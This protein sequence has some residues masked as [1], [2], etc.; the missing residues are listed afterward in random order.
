M[1]RADLWAVAFV[2]TIATVGLSLQPAYAQAPDATQMPGPQPQEHPVMPPMNVAT[3]QALPFEAINRNEPDKLSLPRLMAAAVVAQF[4]PEPHNIADVG[5]FQGEF[6]EAFMVRFPEAHA[7]WTDAVSRPEPFARKRLARFGDRV[8]Y[9]V[10]CL[11]GDISDGCIPKNTDVII[12]S[13]VTMHQPLA[14]IARFYEQARAQLPSGGW[15]IILDHVG[16]PADSQWEGPLKR[17]QSEFHAKTEGPPPFVKT[18]VPT[19]A[20]EM[21][22]FKVA[23]FDDVQVVWR[24]FTDA[25]FMA[26]KQ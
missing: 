25:L 1:T 11:D 3:F 20:E 19:F 5:A 17:A 22:A 24:S 23:G 13:W 21:A 7:L 26:R 14:G 12:A 6:L 15:L 4:K 10:A 9:K 16:F 8:A 2:G 18:S